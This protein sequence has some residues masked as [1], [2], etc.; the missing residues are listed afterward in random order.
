[1]KTIQT[2]LA[3]TVLSVS[4]IGV[5]AQDHPN[6]HVNPRWGECSFQLDSALTQNQFQ[7]FTGEAGKV[8][9]FRPVID[10][11]PMGAG[12]VELDI[13]RWDTNIDEHDNAWNHTFVHPDSTHWLIGGPRLPF[14]GLALRAGVTNKMDVGLYWTMR[15][16][17]NYGFF[18]AQVQYNFIHNEE[19]GWAAAGRVSFMH[20]YG[21][22]DLRFNC[23]GLDVVGSKH[24]RL[25]KEW[26]SITPYAY[27][28]M[29]VSQTAEK[30]DLVVLNNETRLG[31]AAGAGANL[32][33]SIL[34]VGIEYSPGS[35]NTVSYKIGVAYDFCKGS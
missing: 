26:L 27:G 25:Y 12:M 30:S 31:F 15:P 23:Y 21:P 11:S 6:L 28:S 19:K 20:M 33:L 17:A 10:A 24:I 13:L 18:G 9:Y 5:S 2:I 8:I 34:R 1:M 14:P 3:L 7:Q 22:E 4:H 29:I 16:G 32:Q 35:L